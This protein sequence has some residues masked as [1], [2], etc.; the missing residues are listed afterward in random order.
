MSLYEH[1][2][3]YKQDLSSTQ[4]ES[5]I[6]THKDLIKEL[7]GKV[8]YEESWGLRNLAYM[9]KDNKKAFYQFMNVNMPGNGNDKITAKLNLNQNVIRYISIKVKEFDKTPTQL[10]KDPE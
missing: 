5:E 9:I 2:L 4:L 7:G 10:S 8:V 3:I 1:V 6:N